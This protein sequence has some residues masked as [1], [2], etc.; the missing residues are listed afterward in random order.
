MQGGASPHRGGP[1]LSL[2]GLAGWQLHASLCVAL[3]CGF[4][5]SPDAAK[6]CL[7]ET[8]VTGANLPCCSQ[9][10][11]FLNDNLIVVTTIIITGHIV[12]ATI[13]GII[14]IPAVVPG[15]GVCVCVFV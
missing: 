8:V 14:C 6:W 7:W 4:L 5:P 13:Q 15:Q 2:Q 3:G 10:T 11:I 1:I 9:M 12:V